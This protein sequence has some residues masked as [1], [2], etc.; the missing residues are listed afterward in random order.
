MI[1]LI[2]FFTAFLPQFAYAQKKAAN[3]EAVL[4][5]S[6]TACLSYFANPKTA[7]NTFDEAGQRLSLEQVKNYF[8]LTS[9]AGDAWVAKQPGMVFGVFIS[10]QKRTCTVI[11]SGMPAQDFHDKYKSFM[12]SI[13]ATLWN[14]EMYKYTEKQGR[15]KSEIIIDNKSS[16]QILLY[17][18]STTP[19]KPPVLS[20]SAVKP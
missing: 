13:L 12:K 1:A 11:P 20:F 18:A 10:A 8:G 6:S 2:V 4:L 17:Q 15:Q 5:F 3:T 7:Y 9:F 14:D 19:E 16:G